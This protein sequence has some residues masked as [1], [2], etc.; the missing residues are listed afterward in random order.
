MV[1]KRFTYLATFGLHSTQGVGSRTHSTGKTSPCKTALVDPST[2]ARW[3]NRSSGVRMLFRLHE[4]AVRVNQ[5]QRSEL[6]VA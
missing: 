2:R 6:Q 3:I 4:T 1:R 5:V